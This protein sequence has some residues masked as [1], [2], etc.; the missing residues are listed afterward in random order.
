MRCIFDR[1][2]GEIQLDDDACAIMNSQAFFRLNFIH[3]LGGSHFVFPSAVHTRLEHS[4]GVAHLASFM[5]VHFRTLYP[6]VVTDKD[7]TCLIISGLCHDLGH[8]PFSH[9]FE[10][11]VR[12]HHCPWWSHEDMTTRIVEEVAKHVETT[13]NHEDWNFVKL[14]ILGLSDDAPWPA[15]VGR[16]QEKRFL[17]DVVHNR[18]N[19]IDVDRMDYLSR[20][21]LSVFGETHAVDVQRI[22][23]S[24]RRCSSS[25]HVVFD[26]KADCSIINMYRLRTRLFTQVYQ[27]RKVLLAEQ[28]MQDMFLKHKSDLLS[29]IDTVDKFMT[30]TDACLQEIPMSITVSLWNHAWKMVGLPQRVAFDAQ[31]DIH[32]GTIERDMVKKMEGVLKDVFEQQT[33]LKICISSIDDYTTLNGSTELQQLVKTRV[34]TAYCFV[35]GHVVD[36]VATV[37]NIEKAFGVCTNYLAS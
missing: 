14:L 35:P 13:L 23:R 28:L 17:V 11:F 27:H 21:A 2:H 18:T 5:G 25:K 3:Q 19:G 12:T 10:V 8:G 4:L 36:D 37:L 6:D 32:A 16:P 31:K 20:D 33:P 24:A 26:Y 15:D 29:R 9:V 1:V 34:H 22:V 30:L 7:V